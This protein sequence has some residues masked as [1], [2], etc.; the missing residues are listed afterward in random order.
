[1]AAP[2]N[3][4]TEKAGAQK[5]GTS[6]SAGGGAGSGSGT[7][8]QTEVLH[9]GSLQQPVSVE[10]STHMVIEMYHSKSRMKAI[11]CDDLTP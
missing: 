8:T 4:S 7:R 6:S 1:M 9:P 3:G 5:A 11:V 2:S 10:T